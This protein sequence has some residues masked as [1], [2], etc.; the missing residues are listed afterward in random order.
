MYN[1]QSYVAENEKSEAP[2]KEFYKFSLKIYCLSRKYW[3]WTKTI[4]IIYLQKNVIEF[5]GP[6][7]GGR[8]EKSD[9]PVTSSRAMSFGP[10]RFVTCLDP[11]ANSI[12]WFGE[13]T[14]FKFKIEVIFPKHTFEV[15]LLIVFLRQH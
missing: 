12:K 6:S 13:A 14:P 15:Y 11:A 4:F 2:E 7:Q 8:L 3:T 1:M 9:P 5:G 10:W